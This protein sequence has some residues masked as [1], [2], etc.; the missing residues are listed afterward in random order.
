MKIFLKSV[1]NFIVSAL[2]GFGAIYL[3]R[4]YDVL[5]ESFNSLFNSKEEVKEEVKEDD[6]KDRDKIDK[7]SI[8][9]TM[10][11]DK[12]KVLPVAVAPELNL[13]SVYVRLSVGRTSYHYAVYGLKVN[14]DSGSLMYELS[15][16]YGHSYTSK[17]GRFNKVSANETGVYRITVRNTETDLKSEAYEISGFDMQPEIGNRL[18]E[19][20]LTDFLKNGDYDREDVKSRLSETLTKSVKVVCDNADYNANTIQEVFMSVNLESWKVTVTSLEYDCLGRVIVINIS[21]S[22]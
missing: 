3:I 5:I 11:I 1:L 16:D 6:D 19:T 15:D 10:A 20:E 13:S 17:G 2:V 8:M 18:T 7:E 4:N 22:R 12:G 21:A 9:D 14:G